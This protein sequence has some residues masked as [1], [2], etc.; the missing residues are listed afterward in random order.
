MGLLKISMA[1]NC[2][3]DTLL[4]GLLQGICYNKHSA[5]LV[6]HICIFPPL[7]HCTNLPFSSIQVDSQANQ[8]TLSGS[9]VFS[10]ILVVLHSLE[11][12]QWV[13]FLTNQ[14]TIPFDSLFVPFGQFFAL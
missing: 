4:T 2:V 10:K 8:R 11:Y 14:R 9:L 6:L 5:V 13:W 1:T 7:K 12:F 3:Q